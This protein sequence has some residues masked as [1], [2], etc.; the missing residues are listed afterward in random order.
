MTGLRARLLRALFAAATA[1]AWALGVRR[2]VVLDNLRLAFPERSERER[3]ALA[4][5]VYRNL[6]RMAA[7]FLLVERL[8]PAEVGRLLVP[9]HEEVLEEARAR[10][11]GFIA[12]TAHLGHFELLAAA[13]AL[14]GQPVTMITRRMGRS[15]FNDLWRRARARAGIEDLQVSRGETLRAARAA[16]AR[17]QRARL[18]HRPEPA[19]PERGLSALLRGARRHLAHPRRARPAHRGPGGL[20][21][22]ACRSATAVTGWCT[23]GR[24]RCPGPA[25]SRATCSPSCRT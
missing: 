24:S 1:L 5:A 21:R 12:C 2:K 20:R 23:R 4:R 10:G 6:G 16:L 9:E 22:H 11:P 15:R 8:S 25:T 19:A 7:D 13:H 18:R 14:R 17:G 3:R